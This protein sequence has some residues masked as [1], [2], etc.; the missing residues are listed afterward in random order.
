MRLRLRP[1]CRHQAVRRLCSAESTGHGQF[2]QTRVLS[3]FTSCRALPLRVLYFEICLS[4]KDRLEAAV[5]TGCDPVRRVPFFLKG[6]LSQ[7][8][9]S[10][11]PTVFA[12]M[13]VY[14]LG[15]SG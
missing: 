5:Y 3:S 4:P 1:G 13:S 10:G 8:G 11:K 2:N 14:A 9:T 6:D 15:K 12:S 7:S